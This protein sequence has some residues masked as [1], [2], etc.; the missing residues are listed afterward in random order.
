MDAV[1]RYL[2]N[3]R[4]I[5]SSGAAVPET[6]YYPPLAK[7]LN[8]V[9]RHAQ[10][11]GALHHQP[12]E[13]RRRHPRRRPVHGRPVPSARRGDEPLHRPAARARRDRG[14]AAVGDDVAARR[15][16][17]QVTPLPRDVPPGAGHQPTASSCS[18][19]TTPTARPARLETLLARARARPR[20]GT[21]AAHPRDAGAARA[22]SASP[23]SSSGV[24]L[25]AGAA[26]RAAGPRLVP[27]LLRARRPRPRSRSVDLPALGQHCARALEEALGMKLLGREGRALLPLHARPD[28][29]LRRLLR[30]GALGRAPAPARRSQRALRLARR[31]R[32]TCTCPILQHALRPDFGNPAQ[33][34]PLRPR[35]G[36]RLGR[37]GPQPRRPRR[38][39]RDASSRAT[40]CSTSTSRSSR[41]STR[42]CARS[43]A[44]GTRRPRS[45]STWSRA[46]TPC[47]AR[48]WTSPTASP[49]RA[50]SSSTPAAAPAPTWSRCSS[51][52]ARDAAREGRRR[53]ARPRPQAGRA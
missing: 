9:G 50:S 38:L 36:A 16:G 40:P 18:S 45:C 20:S 1:E 26:R 47:C 13:P 22:A 12:R 7:L 8:E 35:R 41:R 10:A 14:Q 24:M 30:L 32:G 43:S 5:A 19:A 4:L 39:L 52:I 21:L 33:L 48:S 28:A 3:V 51:A 37:R 23:S 29:L 25:H 49:T 44:S 27:R 15:R 53:A 17:E 34:R 46:S 31:P 42:S 11:Q 6:S 2:E